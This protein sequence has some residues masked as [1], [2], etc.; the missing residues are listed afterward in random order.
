VPA[1]LTSTIRPLDS[2]VIRLHF[3]KL[4]DRIESRRL[5]QAMRSFQIAMSKMRE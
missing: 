5:E 3:V 2:P 4:R 1:Q